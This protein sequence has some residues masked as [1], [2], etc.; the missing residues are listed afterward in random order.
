MV[1]SQG[2]LRKRLSEYYGES[3]IL[4][5]GDRH[6]SEEVVEDLIKYKQTWTPKSEREAGIPVAEEA[7]I[8]S[9]RI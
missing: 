7:A 2:K 3:F 5:L 6:L 1:L 8:R 9:S 4:S